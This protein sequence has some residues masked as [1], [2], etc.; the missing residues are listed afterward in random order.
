M[1]RLSATLFPVLALGA[2]SPSAGATLSNGAATEDRQSIISEAEAQQIYDYAYPLVIMKISQDLMLTVPFR[3]RSVPNHFIH[4]KQLAMPENR[5]VVLGNRNTLYSVGW[6]D[7]SKGPVVFE[8]PDMGERY[9]V[10]PLLDAW[11]NTFKSFGSRTT[12]QQVQKYFIVNSEWSGQVPAGFVKVDSPTNMVWITGR[13]QADNPEDAVSAGKLQDQYKL[14][15]FAQYL[16]ASDPFADYAPEFM[17]MHVRKPVPYSLQMTAE[18][19]YD[20]FFSMWAAN[21]SPKADMAMIQ[22]LNKAGIR[23]SGIS[24]FVDLAPDVQE[25]MR[26]GLKFKQAKYAKDF[27]GGT[28]QSEP[29]I[30]NRE[31]MGVWGTDFER[32][33]YWAMWGLGANLVEDA[34]YGVSQLDEKLKPLQG[35]NVYKIHFEPNN[36]PPT[37]AFWSVTNYDE[38]GYLEANEQ[39]RYSLGSNNELKYNADGSLDFYLSNSKPEIADVNW[40]PAPKGNFKTLL[41][42]YWPDEKILKG[43]WSLPPLIRLKD[44]Q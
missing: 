21:A 10:M 11:T 24:K 26:A 12:G 19:F 6:V 42:I 3:E 38:E 23:S 32:R 34:V 31:R 18:H 7:L 17:A 15:T 36:L 4:F 9:Y 8:I 40:V 29:W 43:Q 28:S 2:L 27:Y 39:N 44:S 1:K 35:H 13:I 22:I 41:R 5:A 30:F 33:T 25:I 16:G 20:S 14:M 37:S